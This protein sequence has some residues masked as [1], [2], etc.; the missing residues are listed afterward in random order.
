M[1]NKP[2]ITQ[3]KLTLTSENSIFAYAYYE[4]QK[5][6]I[7]KS[8]GYFEGRSLIVTFDEKEAKLHEDFA[9]ATGDDINWW[10]CLCDEL[11]MD[12]YVVCS[13]GIYI[14]KEVREW[15]GNGEFDVVDMRFELVS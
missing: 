10:A 12:K 8:T 7:Q 4:D 5:S 3:Q 11:P 1:R 15:D 9:L 2:L 14:W 6:L 13:D